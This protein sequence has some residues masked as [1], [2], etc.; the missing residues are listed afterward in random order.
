MNKTSSLHPAK[1]PFAFLLNEFMLKKKMT[2]PEVYKAINMDRRVF[3]KIANLSGH[4]LP[5]KT[6]AIALALALHC[7]EK[8]SKSLIKRAGYILTHGLAFDRIILQCLDE[9]VY[10]LMQV[11]LRLQEAGL[12]PINVDE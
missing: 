4:H 1:P 2:A 10:D 7:D 8:E 9:K 12:S 11:N 6:N 3:S 5:S